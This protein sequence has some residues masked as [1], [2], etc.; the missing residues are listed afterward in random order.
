MRRCSIMLL[1]GAVIV[2]AAI[3]PVGCQQEKR[4]DPDRAEITARCIEYFARVKVSDFRVMYDFE[5]P[6]LKDRADLTEYLGAKVFSQPAPDSLEGIQIDSI[7][8]WGDSAYAFLHLEY[9]RSDSTYI[10]HPV[11]NRWY[12]MDGH[13]IK[14]TMSTL[15]KQK[16]Y[17]EEIRIYWEAVREK[18]AKEGQG[19]SGGA[20]S[21]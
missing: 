1:G 20:D 2:L 16:E 19:G 5:L 7:G 21:R 12:K 18:Q 8:V 10:T 3:I 9:L 17:E 14:P 4:L 13:W 11:R 6:Y 15:E